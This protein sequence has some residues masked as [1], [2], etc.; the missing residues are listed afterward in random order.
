MKTKYE[1]EQKSRTQKLICHKETINDEIIRIEKCHEQV[2]SQIMKSTK[3]KLIECRE[4]IIE[5]LKINQEITCSDKTI[6]E[7]VNYDFPSENF[8]SIFE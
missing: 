3:S 8:T 6:L 4:R 1:K 7:S 2:Q 5:E